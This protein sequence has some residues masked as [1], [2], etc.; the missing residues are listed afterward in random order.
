MF[1]PT[2]VRY[3]AY[4]IMSFAIRQYLFWRFDEQQKSES[5]LPVQHNHTL[6]SHPVETT[7]AFSG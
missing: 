7:L 3:V 1:V 6:K 2:F 4:Y 5:G